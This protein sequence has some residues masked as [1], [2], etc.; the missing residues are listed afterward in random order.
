MYSLIP[1]KVCHPWFHILMVIIAKHHEQVLF[2]FTFQMSPWIYRC[3]IKLYFQELRAGYKAASCSIQQN[4]N[5]NSELK[6][7]A[8]SA[9]QQTESVLNLGE[10]NKYEKRMLHLN[11]ERIWSISKKGKHWINPRWGELWHHTPIDTW[12]W[13]MQ[14][15]VR[16]ST[17]SFH[18]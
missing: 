9:G 17:S 11:Y 2:H 5:R 14:I 4:N 1:V 12:W 7:V 16:Q 13:K 10:G 3:T 8:T 6:K 18:Y 15:P